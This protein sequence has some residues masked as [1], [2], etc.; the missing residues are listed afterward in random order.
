MPKNYP[1]CRTNLNSLNL[2]YS[3]P[4]EMAEEILVDELMSSSCRFGDP[5]PADFVASP[6]K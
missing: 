6:Q 4:G 1:A 2:S 5:N 3:H